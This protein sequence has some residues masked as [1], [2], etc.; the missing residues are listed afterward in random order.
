[1]ELHE[2]IEQI[3]TDKFMQ[4]LLLGVKCLGEMEKTTEELLKKHKS[5]KNQT[6]NNKLHDYSGDLIDKFS[7][8]I[9]KFILPASKEISVFCGIGNE[10]V[11]NEFLFGYSRDDL[12]LDELIENLKQFVTDINQIPE[13][14]VMIKSDEKV[15]YVPEDVFDKLFPEDDD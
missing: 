1:M 9:D 6:I 13:G 5:K 15:T 8:T 4:M 2:Q 11:I 10:D 14:H 7:D 12:T 3:R